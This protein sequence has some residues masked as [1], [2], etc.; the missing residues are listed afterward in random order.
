MGQA[1]R[2]QDMLSLVTGLTMGEKFENRLNQQFLLA[3][4]LWDVFV[5]L[6]ILFVYR[7]RNP[8]ERV[9]NLIDVFRSIDNLKVEQYETMS[10]SHSFIAILQQRAL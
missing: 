1:S 5:D 6:I 2:I 9:R 3:P 8:R 4:E 7:H 10:P